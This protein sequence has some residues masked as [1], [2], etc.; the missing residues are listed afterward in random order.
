QSRGTG[1]IEVYDLDTGNGAG[2]GNSTLRN[3]ST[4]G[5]VGLNDDVMI[6]GF[7]IAGDAPVK[8]IM[9]AIGPSLARAGLIHALT[10]PILELYDKGGSMIVSN[11]NWR[12]DQAQQIIDTTIP[13]TDDRE[14]AIVATLRPGPYTAIVRGANNSQGV[15]L[16]EVYA[17]SR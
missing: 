3:I 17:L 9:R 4:R 15:A 5:E 11:D 13:P 7:I 10:H 1:L 12:S 2:A 6:G 14:A 16:V 8:G